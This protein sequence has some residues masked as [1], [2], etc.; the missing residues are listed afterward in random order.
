MMSPRFAAEA[1]KG[2]D[3]ML[4]W[5]KNLYLG[6]TVR[7]QEKKLMRRLEKGRPAPGVWLVTIAS[8][9]KNNL[10]LLPSELFLQKTFRERCPMI[11][12]MGF[13]KAEAMEI[14]ME[15]AREVYEETENMNIRD[16]LLERE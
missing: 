4:R 11:V 5:Y 10:D 15:I 12:G 9:D 13:T 8:N 14:L 6:N 3:F 7:G 16:W 2:W 1:A